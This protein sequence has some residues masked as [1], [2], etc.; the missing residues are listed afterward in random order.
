MK[1]KQIRP[2][3]VEYI[4]EHIEEGVLYISERYRTAVHKCCCG[5][6]Q[7][8]VTPLSPAE[9]SVRCTDARVSMWPS[10]GNW[11]YPCRSH[12]VIRDSR[13]LEA[14]GMSERQIQWVKANDRADKTAQIRHTN[15]AKEEAAIVNKSNANIA[16]TP[17]WQP[18]SW[19]Q[20]LIRWWKSLW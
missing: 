6:G 17:E 12:Y 20:H 10:I 18:M 15:L 11:S 14:K 9:W 16:P 2:E 7:E 8:V 5:C 1:I 19:L 4:P 3:Y 13:V